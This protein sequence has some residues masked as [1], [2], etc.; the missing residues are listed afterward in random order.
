VLYTVIG[1]AAA[2]GIGALWYFQWYRPKKKRE[3][4]A[5]P[6]QGAPEHKAA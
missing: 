2:G 3:E 4:G 6:K 5:R 1:L